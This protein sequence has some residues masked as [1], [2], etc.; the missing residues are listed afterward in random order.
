MKKHF[1]SAL[2]AVG[3][4]ATLNSCSKEEGKTDLKPVTESKIVGSTEG[5]FIQID[6]V[7]A[8]YLQNKSLSFHKNWKSNQSYNVIE[9]KELS[10]TVLPRFYNPGGKPPYWG[11][12]PYV[13]TACSSFVTVGYNWVEK[14]TLVFQ[15]SKKVTEFGFELNTNGWREEYVA[16]YW[17]KSKNLKIGSISNLPEVYPTDPYKVYLRG[18]GASLYAVKSSVP[19]DY[20]EVQF[21]RIINWPD[22]TPGAYYFSNLKY[23][24]AE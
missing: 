17:D 19:F 12:R 13:E 1:L 15:L 16:T 21:A 18:E 6:T 24:L 7:T 9:N 14:T 10:V 5:T 22:R 4:L 11:K 3:L 8:E 20:V 23:K 2:V